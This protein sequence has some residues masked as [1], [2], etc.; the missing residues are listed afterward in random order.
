MELDASDGKKNVLDLTGADAGVAQRR[1]SHVQADGTRY[2]GE[3]ASG[4][5]VTRHNAERAVGGSECNASVAAGKSGN[6]EQSGRNPRDPT[7]SEDCSNFS[8]RDQSHPTPPDRRQ[9]WEKC[10]L[11]RS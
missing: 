1:G 2:L 9:F 11:R 7:I 5:R 4:S 3:H 10:I 6:K 8:S